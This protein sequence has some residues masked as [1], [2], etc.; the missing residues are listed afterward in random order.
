MKRLLTLMFTC[1]FSLVNFSQVKWEFAKN[2][3]KVSIPFTLVNNL[4]V[5]KANL[6]NTELNLI[7]DT[8]S[9][10]NI[11]FSFPEKDSIT[12]KN[13]SKIRIT[14]PGIKEPMDA[15]IS[16]TNKLQLKNLSTQN[17]DVILLLQE[18]F[19]LSTSVGI[20]IHG[21]LGADF[22]KE[23]IVEIQYDQKKI[24]V[25][26]KETKRV[27]AIKNEYKQLPI[28]IKVDKPYLPIEISLDV[29][30]KQS[31]ELLVD[32]GL[33]DGMWIVENKFNFIGNT[34]IADYLGTGLGGDIYGKRAR[35]NSLTIADFIL[36]K[37]II[38]FPDSIA[39]SNK[40]LLIE[41]NGSLGGGILNRFSVLFDYKDEKMYLKANSKISNPFY[42]NMSGINIHHAGYDVVEEK[43]RIEGSVQVV[44][45]NENIFIDSAHRFNYV[46][47]PGFEISH[48]RLNSIADQL[49]LK[50]GDK[51]VSVNNKLASAYTMNQLTELFET[52]FDQEITIEI[53]RKGLKKIVK[54]ILKE[55]I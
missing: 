52:A 51:L 37:P 11:L 18:D 45:L 42:Y 6:N 15:Y 16:K 53:D 17:L 40:N 54:F 21:I 27:T 3:D 46:L 34:T 35:F 36:E 14:G 25:F 26:K 31:L 1:F 43:I 48:I 44:N 2:K 4:I 19:Q 41:R 47:K 28:K 32:T 20:P 49:G 5:V 10:L 9:G 50:V 30:Q 33:S 13:T 22:F 8:G 29:T 24:N 12:F 39:F 7:V 55:E 23:N 38:S